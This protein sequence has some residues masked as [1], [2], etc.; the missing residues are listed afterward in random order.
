MYQLPNQNQNPTTNIFVDYQTQSQFNQN[1]EE[2]DFRQNSQFQFVIPPSNS[3]PEEQQT[4]FFNFNSQ[5]NYS[6]QSFMTQMNPSQNSEN[7]QLLNENI[8]KPRKRKFNQYEEDN[9]NYGY[10]KKNNIHLLSKGFNP[11]SLMDSFSMI[12]DTSTVSSLSRQNTSFNYYNDENYNQSYY[13][14]SQ[15]NNFKPEVNVSLKVK[16]YG[17]RKRGI[18]LDTFDFYSE[19]EKYLEDDTNSKRIKI[20][21]CPKF[22][23]ENILKRWEYEHGVKWCCL[24]PDSRR[25]ANKEM[26]KM[27]MI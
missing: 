9:L 19:N 5:G 15:M 21:S 22:N 10:S 3:Q 12:N 17:K 4:N 24:S 27:T 11:N 16:K 8:S 7:I 26:E 14:Q 25:K 13:E 23:D 20:T 1:P 2:V 18:S 6:Q